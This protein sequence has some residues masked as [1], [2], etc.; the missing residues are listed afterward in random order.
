ME[1][2]LAQRERKFPYLYNLKPQTVF[3]GT[4]TKSLP[5]IGTYVCCKNIEIHTYGLQDIFELQEY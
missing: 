3:H 1:R 4:L 2:E 5:S